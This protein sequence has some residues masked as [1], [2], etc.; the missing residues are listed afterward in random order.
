[1]TTKEASKIFGKIAGLLSIKGENPF[2]LRAYESA[3]Q[4]LA[5]YNEPLEQFL[6]KIVHKEVKGFGAQLTA[7]IEELIDTGKINLLGDLIREIPDDLQELLNV[8]GLSGQKIK[9]LH[10]TLG[11][12]NI[13]N[14]KRAC[15]DGSITKVKGYAEKSASSLLDAILFYE[16]HK[17]MFRHGDHEEVL[18]MLLKLEGITLLPTGRSIR[19]DETYRKLELISLIGEKDRLIATLKNNKIILVDKTDNTLIFNFELRNIKI[20]ITLANTKDLEKELFLSSC[21]EDHLSFLK[22]HG[23]FDTCINNFKSAEDIYASLGLPVF[24]VEMREGM[25]ESNYISGQTPA[26][27]TLA[28][29]LITDSNIQG[30]LH[31]HSTYSDGVHSTKELA[32][33]AIQ[34]GYSYIGISD[35]SKSAAYAGGLKE[36]DI[37]RQHEEIDSLNESLAPFRI[38]KGI[39]SDILKNGALDYKDTLLESFD[40]VIASVHNRFNQNGKEMTARITAALKNPYTSILGHPSGRLLLERPEYEFDIHEVL[41][42]AAQYNTAIEINSNPKRLDLSWKYLWKARELGVKTCITPDA[43]A[44]SQFDYIHYGVQLSRKAGYFPDDILNTRN[45]ADFLEMLSKK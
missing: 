43:H 33:A 29:A 39:E 19:K 45:T 25:Y 5:K 9:L 1:M 11:I 14:L 8:K 7:H 20:Q 28:D 15:N 24:P 23:E 44:I 27:H 6:E 41:E 3:V 26:G 31:V 22:S 18:N 13:E 40:F 42:I 38:L 36:D 10:E 32:Q 2:K 12:K 37:K 17:G 30:I 4:N 16:T 21:S 35:H 34:K